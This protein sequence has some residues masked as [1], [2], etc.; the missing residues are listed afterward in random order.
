[1]EVRLFAVKPPPRVPPLLASATCEVEPLGGAG[2]EALPVA[3]LDF[4]NRFE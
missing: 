3:Y 4:E 1:M 2:N